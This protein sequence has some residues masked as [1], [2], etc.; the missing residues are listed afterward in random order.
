MTLW[1]ANR[2]EKR[3]VPEK[4]EHNIHFLCFRQPFGKFRALHHDYLRPKTEELFKMRHI[5]RRC[6]HVQLRIGRNVQGRLAESGS[7]AAK[8]E[9]LPLFDLQVAV[10]TGPCCGV[11]LRYTANSSHGRFVLIFTTFVAGT[12]VS[13]A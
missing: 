2:I 9:S 8:K 7:R 13:S 1:N 3:P 6:Y 5:A 10:E 4:V 12:S 11:R